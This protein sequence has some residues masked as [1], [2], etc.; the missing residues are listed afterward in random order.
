MQIYR[1]ERAKERRTCEKKCQVIF[2]DFF[3]CSIEAFSF[4]ITIWKA[5][6]SCQ[7]REHLLDSSKEKIINFVQFSLPIQSTIDNNA[8]N[9]TS[10]YHKIQTQMITLIFSIDKN[11]LFCENFLIFADKKSSAKS[12]LFSEKRPK[13][14]CK[15]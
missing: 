8:L 9:A 7:N 2:V 15:F 6:R 12:K 11:I 5:L 1:A 4:W 14:I 3:R 13:K 10:C